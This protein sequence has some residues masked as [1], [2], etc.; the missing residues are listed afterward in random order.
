MILDTLRQ[1][2]R[3]DTV[4]PLFPLAA[5]T[6][7]GIDAASL[8]PGRHPLRGEEC[9]LIIARDEGRGTQGAVLEAHRRY[10]DV[11][12]VLDGTDLIGWRPAGD[13]RRIT[14]PYDEAGDV[15]LYGDAPLTWC[16]VGG[17]LFALFFPADA[18]APL[19]GTGTLSRAIVK[20]RI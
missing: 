6:L 7:R 15:E 10:I 14:R 18:H 3:Y 1:A 19:G 5:A 12:Y 13:C 4:H 2:S 9:V 16:S 17:P 20:I 11:Q 8:P